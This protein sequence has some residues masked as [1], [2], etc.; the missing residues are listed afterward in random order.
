M[1]S[2]GQLAVG[3]FAECHF[4]PVNGDRVLAAIHIEH[5]IL[6]EDPKDLERSVVE[7]LQQ[8]ARSVMANVHIT[9]GSQGVR[10]VSRVAA[11]VLMYR[12]QDGAHV[13]LELAEERRGCLRVP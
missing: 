10:L 13:V 7:A 11:V 9:G 6:V 12:W 5:V 2:R 1:V 3:L 4:E 8:T